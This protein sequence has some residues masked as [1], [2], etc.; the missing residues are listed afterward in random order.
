MMQVKTMT[1]FRLL[2]QEKGWT[3]SQTFGARFTA[4]ARELAAE[5][6]QRRLA[7]VTVSQRTFNRWMTGDI[8]TMP[9]KDT[10]RILEH[11][12]QQPVVRLF[13]PPS[14]AVITS[15]VGAPPAA[16]PVL[17][18]PGTG[19]VVDITGRTP[20]TVPGRPVQP[21]ILDEPRPS[22]DRTEPVNRRQF[23]AVSSVAAL[24]V[25]ALA[26]LASPVELAGLPEAIVPQHINQLADAASRLSAWDHRDG[27]GGLVRRVAAAELEWAA[28]SLRCPCPELLR[29]PLFSAVAWLAVVVGASGFDAHHHTDARRAFALAT[30]CAEEAGDW[31]LR[32]KAYSMRA[33]QEIWTGD[34]DLGLTYAE[35]GLARSD[36]LTATEQAMLHA[37]RAR[38]FAKMGDV[39]Q[40][41]RAIGL[42]DE[43]FEHASPQD[44]PLW[45][46]YYDEAQHQGDTGHALYD[47]AR[48]GFAPE[49]S[50]HRLQYAV[51]HHTEAYVRSRAISRTKLASLTMLTGDP[52]EATL[53][54]QMALDEVGHL[55]SRRAAAD[56]HELVEAATPHL[57]C[58][59]TGY[60]C[61]RILA[62]VPA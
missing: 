53:I 55:T 29:A 14:K 37:A 20:S 1:L 16:P 15:A 59:D 62:T 32:A 49:R 27:G 30:A 9:Q 36:R 6:G 3:T 43:C 44:E 7:D 17:N 28:A 21:R 26:D 34:P 10:R 40:T 23:L 45:M 51:D 35:I 22:V 5:T 50:V 18:V 56:M 25:A 46:R 60:L 31:H 61:E 4:A 47:L 2:V 33:R 38:A 57:R 41:L 8:K 52:Q 11:L 19:N 12:L 48:S 13:G 39:Q 54:G 42:A 24:S 58:A